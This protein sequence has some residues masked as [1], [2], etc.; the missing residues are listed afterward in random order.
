MTTLIEKTKDFNLEQNFVDHIKILKQ[1][2]FATAVR[3]EANHLR[4]FF[5]ALA[6]YVTDCT[7][8]YN[9]KRE[10]VRFSSAPTKQLKRLFKNGQTLNVSADEI[11]HAF[12]N[13]A[14][15]YKSLVLSDVSITT[16]QKFR[17]FS[18]SY[19]ASSFFY[20][21]EQTVAFPGPDNLASFGGWGFAQVWRPESETRITLPVL[22]LTDRI[23]FDELRIDNGALIRSLE[24]IN[25]ICNHDWL[26]HLT[27]PKVN[28]TVVFSNA[29]GHF[30]HNIDNALSRVPQLNDTGAEAYEAFCMKT[31]AALLKTE[32]ARPIWQKLEQQ[33]HE[34]SAN[35]RENFAYLRGLKGDKYQDYKALHYLAISTARVLRRVEPIESPLTQ[36]FLKS[37]LGMSTR[38]NGAV[39]HARDDVWKTR[40]ADWASYPRQASK[41][42][43]AQYE[44]TGLF[45]DIFRDNAH[46]RANQE[47]ATEIVGALQS[48]FPRPKA[49]LK[50]ENE[51]R[52]LAANV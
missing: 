28:N 14:H 34:F 41:T 29:H 10:A 8:D 7:V 40:A 43:T 52:A 27:M 4:P 36:T 2:T 39:R 13:I 1:K 25:R 32:T 18:R 26:H 24:S 33:V 37:V 50:W 9:K 12:T 45:T 3:D 11:S 30:G 17:K 46:T 48:G 35:L 6:E 23:K 22:G 20:D 42:L 15:K 19:T 31:H 21:G 16:M 44:K 5:D 47:N 51:P 38:G 49:R